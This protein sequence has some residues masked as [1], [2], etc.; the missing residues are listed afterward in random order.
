MLGRS[1]DLDPCELAV[2]FGDPVDVG[3]VPERQV[4]RV[5]VMAEPV[6]GRQFPK[7]PLLPWVIHEHMFAFWPDG[8][9]H[10][11]RPGG[12]WPVVFTGRVRRRRGGAAPRAATRAS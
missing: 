12:T 8:N 3:A 4:Q 5:A 11:P 1:L 7:V 2:A 9:D 6:D 10:R